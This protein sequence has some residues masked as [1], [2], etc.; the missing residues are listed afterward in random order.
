MLLKKST[1]ALAGN[2]VSV[3]AGWKISLPFSEIVLVSG[4]EMRSSMLEV[5]RKSP[6]SALQRDITPDIV[7]LAINSKHRGQTSGWRLPKSVKGT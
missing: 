4:D 1:G 7:H 6:S 3:V 2:L 5:E